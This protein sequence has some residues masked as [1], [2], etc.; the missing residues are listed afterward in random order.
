MGYSVA[1]DPVV[2]VEE[3]VVRTALA[4]RHDGDVQ[5][6]GLRDGPG[7]AVGVAQWPAR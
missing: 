2:E 7:I 6:Q 3:D 5:V 4:D 1:G